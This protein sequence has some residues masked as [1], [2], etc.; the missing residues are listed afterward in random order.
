M[1]SGDEDKCPTVD[2]VDRGIGI[3]P[4]DFPETILSLQSGNKIKKHYLAGAF[5]QGGAATLAFC[6]YTVIVSR[7]VQCPETV[8]F[9]VI[10]LMN[11]GEAYKENAYVYLAV[12]HEGSGW[13]VPSCTDD[14]PI[15]LYKGISTHERLK[16]FGSGTLVRHYGYE[17]EGFEKTLNPHPGNLYHLLHHM[18][19]DPLLPFRVLDLRDS[20]SIKDEL[21][22]GSR[23]RLM[24]QVGKPL[25]EAGE[26][27]TE[28]RHY[29]AREM[30]SPLSEAEPSVGIEYW[31]VL[32]I[33]KRGGKIG[34]RRYSND[35]FVDH[36]HPIIGTLNG[37]N[38]GELTNLVVRNLQ[39][40]MVARHIVIHIDASRAS[41]G[42]R[43]SLFAS[44]REGFKDGRA[45]G[46][47]M[48]VL[49]NKIE[50]D[51]A[52][53]ALERELEEELLR[54][55]TAEVNEEVKQEI[56][57]LLRDAGFEVKDPGQ[58]PVSGKGGKRVSAPAHT[59]RTFAPPEPLQTLPYP[60]VTRFEIVSPKEKLAVHKQNNHIVRV[61]TDASFRF[62]REKRVAIR[63]EPHGLEVA[64]K[65]QLRGG[66][67]NWRLR[68][69]ETS[70]VGDTGEVV[71]TI[72]RPDGSQLEDR[73]PY[74]ILPPRE[75]ETKEG[76]GL[77]P[78]FA[79]QA[80]S[81]YED[82]DLFRNVW[83]DV[84]Q[85]EVRSVAYRAM[86][87]S[88]KIVVY[89]ST[90]FSPY[91]QQLEEIKKRTSLA[92]LFRKNYEIWIGYHAILQHQQESDIPATAGVDEEEL[93]R[94]Q[95]R[96]RALVAEMQAKQAIRT[97]D[98]QRQVLSTDSAE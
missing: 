89:Y 26:T 20:D 69:T 54:K 16:E 93:E 53:H 81:P 2:V 72:T 84:D 33:R 61:E 10:K 50:E 56:V 29:A 42:V 47:L 14:G 5:G 82:F 17:L 74:E 71:V 45:K 24:K 63:T 4:Q 6:E 32:S 94:I 85:N 27:G 34:P 15:R 76:K 44:T 87:T 40:R 8:G 92:D 52:L 18:M 43:T 66:R 31:V 95:E 86:K 9:T 55:E 11:L 21:V 51:E 38:Q 39:L 80:I 58:I 91:K 67:V 35:L 97:A 48:R 68:P 23:N 19:F 88:Q 98:M 12:Q 25:L 64:S 59:K 22:T 1:T 60:K 49:E 36:R 78:P 41:K 30:V 3:R 79:I 57:S 96:E 46:E 90:E 70:S 77:V 37:Q 65:S 75:E 73:L 7:H 62:D 28:L 83:P 13:T